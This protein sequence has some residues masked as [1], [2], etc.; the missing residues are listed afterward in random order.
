VTLPDTQHAADTTGLRA[1]GID[2]KMVAAQDVGGRDRDL[3][4][5]VMVDSTESAE[6]VAKVLTQALQDKAGSQLLTDQGSPYMAKQTLELLDA[7]DVEHA[8]QREAD[9]QG[10]ATIER[11]FGTCKQMLEP[12]LSIT[13][14]MA[15]ALPQLA[16]LDLARATVTVLMT[17]LLRAYQA[18]A[19]AAHRADEQRG[20]LNEQALARA[21]AEQRDSARADARSVRLLLTR[22]HGAY[23]LPGSPQA[24][25]RN[26]RGF[27]LPVLQE[28]ERRFCSQ[29]HRDDIRNRK[30]YFA[31]IACK[32]AEE[33]RRRH[34]QRQAEGEA[35]R[36]IEQTHDQYQQ[37]MQH[38]H[39]HP[40]RWLHDAL[41]AIAAQ[42]RPARR[43]LFCEGKGFGLAWLED[44]LQR[45]VQ[46][47]GDHAAD[48]ARGVIQDWSLQRLN[49]LGQDGIDAVLRA[50]QP[51]LET[52]P[53]PAE[54]LL[55][56][57][58]I[59]SDILKS[60]G[61]PARSAPP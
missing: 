35:N 1:F 7:L 19:R 52:L 49:A 22:I 3:L 53:A 25:I 30:S 27:G 37:Q 20:G 24:F 59:V 14:R 43:L 51:Y 41:D 28:S 9:P 32:V 11:A 56:P 13:D 61:P 8:P 47:H 40:Q 34:A 29:V 58:H 21:A 55:F 23:D 46:L 16:D 36:K 2:L 48:L 39:S 60:T 18:G 54:T 33:F 50:A 44:A 10:K 45:L 12:L 38:W 31:A 6:H 15:Q 4:D 26:L 17:L 57:A 42:W 5:A